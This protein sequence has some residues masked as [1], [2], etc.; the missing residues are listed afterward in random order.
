MKSAVF[1]NRKCIPTIYQFR[2]LSIS[3]FSSSPIHQFCN[4]SIPQFTS[5]QFSISAVYQFH[6]L[7]NYPSAFVS[8]SLVLQYIFQDP[9][10]IKRDEFV[11]KYLK[12]QIFTWLTALLIPSTFALHKYRFAGSCRE[13]DSGTFTPGSS[14]KSSSFHPPAQPDK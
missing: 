1:C 5:S 11:S 9:C 4:I 7:I 2:S 6:K 14:Y 3:K 13:L 12:N 10:P 8:I